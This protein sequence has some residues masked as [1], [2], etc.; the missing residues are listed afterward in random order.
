MKKLFN[1]LL[2]FIFIFLIVSCNPSSTSS[3]NPPSSPNIPSSSNNNT[4]SSS[5]DDFIPNAHLKDGRDFDDSNII[6]T[7]NGFY[8]TKYEVAKYIHLFNKLPNNYYTKFEASQMDF[9]NEWTSENKL[10]IGG[11]KFYNREGYLP[12]RKTYIECDIGS[13]RT[14]RGAY[15][16]VF[17]N[18]FEVY[19]THDHYNNFERLY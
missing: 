17:S 2:S 3:S 7:I 12:L 10:S 6:V 13:K 19:Y 15:R 14:T 5:S 11:D 4:S 16:I 8:N 9:F 18:T 1:F